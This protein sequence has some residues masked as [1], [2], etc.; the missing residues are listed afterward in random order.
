MKKI[1]ALI[2]SAALLFPLAGCGRYVSHYKA[3]GFVH[4]N[5]SDSAFM[6]FYSF[7]GRMVFKLKS[8]AGAVLHYAAKLESGSA[9]VYYDDSGTKRELCTLHAA[10][11]VEPSD[12]P[13]EKG[14]LY[15]IVETDGA[16][17]NGEFQFDTAE[18]DQTKA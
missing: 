8:P 16:C 10:D 15:I 4:A 13:V 1:T 11:S 18:F 9:V 5:Q 2:L 3:V 17:K 12:V 6:S 14:T 7:D